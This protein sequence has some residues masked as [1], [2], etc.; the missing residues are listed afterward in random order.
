VSGE[1]VPT[2][3]RILDKEY[4]VSCPDG[5]QEALYQSAA[6][7]NDRMQEARDGGN[8]IGTERIAVMAAL[9][10]VHDYLGLVREREAHS[11]DLDSVVQR[12]EEKLSASIAANRAPAEGD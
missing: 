5:E 11:A 10:L 8:V 1:P 7:L 12:L 2:S 6:F 4:V 9:N 3:I